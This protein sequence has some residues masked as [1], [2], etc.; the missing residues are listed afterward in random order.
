MAE[1][2][3]GEIRTFAFDYAPAGWALCAGQVLNITQNQTLFSLLGN[4]YGGDGV[5]TFGLPDL[6]G[7]VPRH[8]SAAD[9]YGQKAGAETM[10]LTQEYLPA[11][12]HELRFK[13]QAPTTNNP[14]QNVLGTA[15]LY[16]DVKNIKTM[17]PNA[18]APTAGQAHNNLQPSL[19][20]NY[21]IALQGIFP[22][23]S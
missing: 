8:K 17:A 5:A 13:N 1:P 21:C 2:F 23:R 7:R 15:A 20:L 14:G 12:S 19:V 3:I 11:H 16:A 4:R 9:S 18:L 22:P 10:L 6:Q